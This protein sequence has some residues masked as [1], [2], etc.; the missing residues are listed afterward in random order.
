MTHVVL[1]VEDSTERAKLQAERIAG[2]DW[3]PDALEATVV[4]VF[5]DN[6]E[7]TSISQFGPAR[8][9]RKVLEEAGIDV[10]YDE[11]SGDPDT[12]LVEY[13]RETGADLVCVAGRKRSPA[14]KAVFGSVSQSVMF[15]VDVPVLFCPYGGEG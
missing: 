8:R 4:H 15:N 10:E 3:A 2:L 14:G 5:T 13:V 11:L 6:T 12:R 1:A 7:G 9:A